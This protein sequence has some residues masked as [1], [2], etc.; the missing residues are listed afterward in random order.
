EAREPDPRFR[1][2]ELGRLR[3]DHD[4]RLDD[5]VESRRDGIAVDG[6]NDRLV[7]GEELPATPA[8][9]TMHPA[10]LRQ[11]LPRPQPGR[12][13]GRPAQV[14]PSTEAATGSRDDDNLDLVVI[15]G[16]PHLA[17]ELLEAPG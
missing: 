6:G 4:V 13:H 12:F 9:R 14:Y 8:A 2:S 5:Q 17:A 11:P 15:L 16:H 10:R 7:S 3:R 1:L